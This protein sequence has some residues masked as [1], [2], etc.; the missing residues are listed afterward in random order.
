M[1]PWQV[2]CR[3]LG[4]CVLG[5]H[6]GCAAGRND[7]RIDVNAP[8]L[9]PSLPSSLMVPPS[10]PPSLPSRPVRACFHLHG[11]VSHTWQCHQRRRRA[12][13]ARLGRSG[14]RPCSEPRLLPCARTGRVRTRS[15]AAAAATTTT[16]AG[17]GC[18]GLGRASG[19]MHGASQAA[20]ALTHTRWAAVQLHARRCD[21]QDLRRPSSTRAMAEAVG[22][23]QHHDDLARSRPCWPTHSQVSVPQCI[24]Q[25][26]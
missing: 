11:R 2:Y 13:A 20:R 8:S 6:G 23:P 10:L 3:K 22:H 12:A 9:A 19:A 15:A 14:T 1:V 5:R 16:R 21:G 26:G 7:S 17:S 4:P 18:V 25:R 24:Q